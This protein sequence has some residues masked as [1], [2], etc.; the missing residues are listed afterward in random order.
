M[1]SECNY[2]EELNNIL[3]NENKLDMCLDLFCWIQRSQMFTD[4]DESLVKKLFKIVVGSKRV[5]TN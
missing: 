3:N 4:E 1:P 2:E 5:L